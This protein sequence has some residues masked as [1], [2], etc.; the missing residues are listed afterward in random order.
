MRFTACNDFGA[1]LSR[2]ETSDTHCS[3]LIRFHR[4]GLRIE[5]EL[6]ST[7]VFVNPAA[8]TVT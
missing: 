8:S 4:H 6:S 5:A 2:R 7:A 3:T 1:V